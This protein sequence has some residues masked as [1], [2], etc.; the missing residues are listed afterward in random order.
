M[1]DHV[2][3]AVGDL[4]RAA[5]FYEAV[6]APLG[7]TRLVTRERTVGFGKRYPEFWLNLRDHHHAA[8]GDPGAHI[9]LRAADEEAVRSF[10]AV[11]LAGGGRDSGA[12]GPRQAAMTT[13]FGAFILDLDG[14][15]IEA[16]TFPA[17]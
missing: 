15:K 7:L 8:P 3:I 12:P 6:L 1:I 10:H 2:S 16:V 5:A 17:A 11:A 14:N 13:Y 9:C 4:A